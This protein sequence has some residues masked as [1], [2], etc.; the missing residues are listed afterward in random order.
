MRTDQID[1]DLSTPRN[2]LVEP[3]LTASA[4]FFA[5]KRAPQTC[6]FTVRMPSE[7]AVE[8]FKWR[9]AFRPYPWSSTA[10]P[11]K[12][13]WNRATRGLAFRHAGLGVKF[14]Q[15]G[16]L[17]LGLCPEGFVGEI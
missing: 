9:L 16:G 13:E 15:R 7:N 6:L 10:P 1:Y 17:S 4:A 2:P 11:S 3:G 5:C 14:P 8:R 12:G